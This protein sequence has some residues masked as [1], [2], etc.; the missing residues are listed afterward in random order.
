MGLDLHNGNS[1]H[2]CFGQSLL[3]HKKRLPHDIRVVAKRI[4]YKVSFLPKNVGPD[5]IRNR[6]RNTRLS[7]VGRIFNPCDAWA[8]RAGRM[9]RQQSRPNQQYNDSS[10]R[11]SSYSPTAE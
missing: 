3:L 7:G 1:F 4:N 10:E 6:N 5:W 11:G 2:I 9:F 8:C